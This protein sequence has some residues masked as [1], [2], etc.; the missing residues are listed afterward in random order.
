MSIVFVTSVLEGWVWVSGVARGLLQGRPLQ[1][2]M[3]WGVGEELTK[4]W[5]ILTNSVYKILLGRFC[6]VFLLPR[7]RA[8]PAGQKLTKSCTWVANFLHEHFRVEIAGVFLAV[9]SE[10]K[11][12][13]AGK[14]FFSNYFRGLYRKIL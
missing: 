11:R 3:G 5:P 1:L 7:A 2:P 14:T 12:L 13:Q 8:N 10:S 6:T 4:S 9:P